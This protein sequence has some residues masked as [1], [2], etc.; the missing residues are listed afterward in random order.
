MSEVLLIK[1]VAATQVGVVRSEVD[2]RAR[3]SSGKDEP[4]LGGDLLGDA[5]LEG[6]DIGGGAFEGLGPE[7]AVGAR[8]NELG[9]DANPFS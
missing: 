4:G 8:I 1:K 7:V 3:R 5:V 2:G 6:E 9:G